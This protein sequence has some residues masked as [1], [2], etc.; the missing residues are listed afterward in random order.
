M[1]EMA[2]LEQHHLIQVL[3]SLMLEAAVVVLETQLLEQVVQVA[4]VMVFQAL[5]V[6]VPT[7]LPIEEAVVVALEAVVV[8]MQVERAAQV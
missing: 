3:Q 8:Q 6:M 5:Q 1:L 7:A 4:A 2:A